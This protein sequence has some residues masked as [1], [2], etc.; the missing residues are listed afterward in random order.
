MWQGGALGRKD[1]QCLQARE[2][3]RRCGFTLLDAMKATGVGDILRGDPVAMRIRAQKPVPA[4]GSSAIEL[5]ARV[6]GLYFRSSSN[7]A[8]SAADRNVAERA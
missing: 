5:L 6:A 8:W 4:S 2:A 1:L 7:A 3:W